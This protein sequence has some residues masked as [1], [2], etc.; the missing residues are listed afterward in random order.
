MNVV[1]FFIGT[2]GF[3][4]LSSYLAKYALNKMEERNQHQEQVVKDYA[5]D[6]KRHEFKEVLNKQNSSETSKKP[7]DF[8]E[9]QNLDKKFAKNVYRDKSGKFKSKK[10]WKEE[11]GTY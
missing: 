2:I 5:E 11:Q 1:L 4:L 8:N 6:T 9:V 3:I 7:K 10:E